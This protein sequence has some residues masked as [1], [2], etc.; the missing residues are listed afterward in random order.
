MASYYLER[1]RHVTDEEGIGE[2]INRTVG[3]LISV[4]FTDYH[5]FKF[6]TFKNHWV[7]KLRYAAPAHPYRTL[8][9]D[10]KQIQYR[11]KRDDHGHWLYP[12]PR[13]GG[14]GQVR[15]GNWD[16]PKNCKSV[17]TIPEIQGIKQRFEKGEDWDQTVYYDYW[18]KKFEKGKFKDRGFDTLDEYLESHFEHY[19]D[20]YYKIKNNGYQPNHQGARKEPGKRENPNVRDRLEV[21]VVIDR[22][23]QIH[24]AEG[25][26]R[27]GIA[28]VLEIKI[29]VHVICRHE[30]WQ[31]Y[32][33][34]I[35]E[36]INN[37][38]S[39]YNIRN[40]PDLSDIVK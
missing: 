28:R 7:N 38:H 30:Q 31:L 37:N 21:L 8:T 13:Y 20:L 22:N 1:A 11:I 4:F 16:L 23:G 14:I 32:R 6:H 5:R 3:C 36:D 29:P 35:Y 15:G 10:P 17:D 2:L 25:H 34:H 39:Y 24:L 26:H 19:E 12:K 33:D 9:I 27:F 40:H 18:S